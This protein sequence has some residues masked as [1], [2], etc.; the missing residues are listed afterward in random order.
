MTDG[1]VTGIV[2]VNSFAKVKDEI[3][4]VETVLLAN[5]PEVLLERVLVGFKEQEQ[6]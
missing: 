4:T 2:I 5:V 6:T 3:D 1:R